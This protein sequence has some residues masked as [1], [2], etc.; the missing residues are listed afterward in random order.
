MGRMT[1]RN[2]E[3]SE[4]TLEEHAATTS[5]RLTG[6]L[7]SVQT[8]HVGRIEGGQVQLHNS[9]VGRVNAHAVHLDHSAAGMVTAQTVE[10]EVPPPVP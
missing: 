6:K 1:E 10:A 9:S 3:H 4:P 8:S 5:E 7:V 2:D